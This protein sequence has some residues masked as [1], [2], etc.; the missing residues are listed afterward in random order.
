MSV[1]WN[2][3]LCDCS[4]LSFVQS[5]VPLLLIQELEMYVS[6]FSGRSP[7]VSSPTAAANAEGVVVLSLRHPCTISSLHSSLKLKFGCKY[8]ACVILV[9]NMH[10][11]LPEICVYWLSMMCVA[12]TT[13]RWIPAVRPLGDS[14]VDCPLPQVCFSWFR[15]MDH[16]SEV[17]HIWIEDTLERFIVC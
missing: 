7:H 8:Q 4:I 2:F 1:G 13:C 6:Q 14:V 9:W 12:W 10:D 11:I 16:V 5:H 17:V 15:L 3:L